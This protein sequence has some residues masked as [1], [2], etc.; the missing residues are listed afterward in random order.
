M[1][2]CLPPRHEDLNPHRKQGPV[3]CA[4]NT[5]MARKEERRGRTLT[6]QLALLKGQS[7]RPMRGLRW[8]GPE[9]HAKV[10]F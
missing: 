1:V 2:K 4:C 7:H 8:K 10:G 3:V 5:V 6:A 9:T